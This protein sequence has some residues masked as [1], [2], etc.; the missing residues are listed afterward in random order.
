ML[1]V[2]A[3][4]VSDLSIVGYPLELLQDRSPFGATIRMR[5]M[6]PVDFPQ[7]LAPISGYSSDESQL[8]D[9]ANED[10]LDAPVNVRR[11]DVMIRVPRM[12]LVVRMYNPA[13]R[14]KP[15]QVLPNVDE[16]AGVGCSGA[17]PGGRILRPPSS[18]TANVS[19][20]KVNW[21]PRGNFM[22]KVQGAMVFLNGA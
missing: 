10:E 2:W 9:N 1:G 14:S 6:S 16:G 4:D 3:P 12:S 8:G 21:V 5:W 11:V 18:P 7:A 20:P 15:E 22:S 13:N 19:Y 17:G